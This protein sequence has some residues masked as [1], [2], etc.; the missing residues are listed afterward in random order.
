MTFKKTLNKMDKGLLIKEIC[1][2]LLKDKKNDCKDLLNSKYPFEKNEIQ[3][4][5][6]SRLQMCQVFLKDGFIDRYTGQKLIFPGL[7]KILTIEF[8]EIIKY[9]KHWKMSETHMIYWE[10]IPTI[11]HLIPVARGGEDNITNW[12][13][14]SMVRN[15]AK[16][17]WTLDEIGWKLYEKGK[18]DEWDGLSNY[19][20]KLIDKKP[21]YEKDNYVK[22]WKNALIKAVEEEIYEPLKY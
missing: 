9:H 19:F 5:N 14:T 2:L 8:P 7:I 13:T 6:Y 22:N 11:D 1:D 3:Q 4:R 15:S 18:L 21:E 20:L 12:F 16:S 17:N 10:L